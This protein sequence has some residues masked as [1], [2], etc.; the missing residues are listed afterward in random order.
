MI[1]EQILRALPNP[2]TKTRLTDT[3]QRGLACVITPAGTKT[4][5]VRV[6]RAGK[7]RQIT[8]GRYPEIGLKEARKRASEAHA[9]NDGGQAIETSL[10]IDDVFKTIYWP[11][12]VHQLKHPKH[13][14]SHWN[15]HISPGIGRLK[16]AEVTP[17]DIQR[18]YG[19]WR[20][21]GLG[22][23]SANPHR[24]VG[25]FFKWC[26]KHHL[27]D[28]SPVPTEKPVKMVPRERVLSLDE[29]RLL[30][31]SFGISPIYHHGAILR[32]LILHI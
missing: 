14:L 11:Q 24:V 9:A 19:D 12:R 7:P 23:G 2:E 27:V 18:L 6:Y 31:D 10:S 20:R 17:L 16:A 30:W 4:F 29:I 22:T 25:H 32:W 5:V 15:R 8:L 3:K 28:R 26:V 1:T 13:D 21:A